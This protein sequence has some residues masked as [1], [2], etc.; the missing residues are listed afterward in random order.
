MYFPVQG[1][2]VP[3]FLETHMK[4]TKQPF[5]GY[6]ACVVKHLSNQSSELCSALRTD[7]ELV[8]FERTL[9]ILK[10]GSNKAGSGLRSNLVR[11]PDPSWFRRY[12]E[13]FDSCL[14]SLEVFRPAAS[15]LPEFERLTAL[16]SKLGLILSFARQIQYAS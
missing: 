7:P 16:T 8:V 15:K 10:K 9:R 11:V 12:D 6:K 13:L 2:C 1:M 5:V 3:V 14:G 4:N